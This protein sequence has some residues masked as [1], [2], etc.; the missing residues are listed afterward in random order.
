MTIDS[1]WIG[2]FKEEVPGAFTSAPPFVPE[3]VFCDGQIKLMCPA[4]GERFA[5]SDYIFR[6]FGRGLQRYLDSGTECVILAFD[7][8]RHVPVAKNMT[9]VGPRGPAVGPRRPAVGPSSPL[10]P[11]R[12]SGAARWAPLS[13]RRASRCL[14]WSRVAS[15]GTS[16]YPIACSRARS[17]S[18]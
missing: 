16:T 6:Q 14:P 10:T 18:S 11:R 13:S 7:D 12:S 15:T 1:T 4:V 9:Q 2:C 3:A 17:S 8:Y 5:W